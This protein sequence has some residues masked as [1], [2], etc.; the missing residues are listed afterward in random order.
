[1]NRL[2]PKR[3]SL[4]LI[5]AALN[6][7]VIGALVASSVSPNLS[8]P[9]SP[10]PTALR[11][12]QGKSTLARQ[13]DLTPR[14]AFDALEAPRERG[15]VPVVPVVSVVAVRFR[16]RGRVAGDSDAVGLLSHVTPIV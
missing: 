2:H 1:M 13:A 12:Q 9:A 11:L 6:A 10:T 14:V 3:P 4:L 15:L 8:H 5:I 16:C 7:L